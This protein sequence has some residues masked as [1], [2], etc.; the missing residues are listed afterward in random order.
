[1]GAQDKPPNAG[2]S[3]QFVKVYRLIEDGKWDDQG[4]GLVTVDYLERSED[5]GLFVVDEG[6]NETLLLHRISSDD[7]YHKQEETIISWRD[8][9]FSTELALSFKEAAG[10]TYIWDRICSVQRNM[11]FGSLT[12]K[13]LPVS[14]I[15]FSWFCASFLLFLSPYFSSSLG[16]VDFAFVRPFVTLSDSCFHKNGEEIEMAILYLS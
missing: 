14:S 3:R 8:P 6:N 2:Y 15:S 1:M 16:C 11:R 10:C 13:C 4:T 7:I 9:D 12:G 5:L